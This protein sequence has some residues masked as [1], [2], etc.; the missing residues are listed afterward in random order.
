MTADITN[1]SKSSPPGSPITNWLAAI[2]IGPM[3]LGMV[4]VNWPSGT[5]SAG[6]SSASSSIASTDG[7]TCCEKGC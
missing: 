5:K 6:R 1:A 3:S 7:S 2:S 4:S